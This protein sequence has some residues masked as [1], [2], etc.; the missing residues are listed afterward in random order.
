MKRERRCCS[1]QRIPIGSGL[2]RRLSTAR[3]I[4]PTG[5][6]DHL[7]IYRI[8]AVVARRL[9][10][11]GT[12]R[13]VQSAQLSYVIG[14]RDCLD[15]DG[16]G[17]G[18]SLSRRENYRIRCT[19]FFRTRGNV[20]CTFPRVIEVYVVVKYSNAE[21]KIERDVYTSIASNAKHAREHS[22]LHE[23]VAGPTGY[24]KM[25]SQKNQR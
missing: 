11:G 19:I 23:N 3:R 9:G 13:Q 21:W 18:F 8:L 1:I 25:F 5:R 17:N 24:C 16:I 7:M 10:E 15:H 6:I 2:S 22:V 12:E 20:K 14:C 4:L